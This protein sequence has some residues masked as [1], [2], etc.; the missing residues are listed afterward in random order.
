M[1]GI[2]VKLLTVKCYLL[3]LTNKME[4]SQKGPHLQN[5]MDFSVPPLPVSSQNLL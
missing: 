1:L 4:I 5:L 2:L 3:I